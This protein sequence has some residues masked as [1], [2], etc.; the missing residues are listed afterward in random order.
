MEQKYINE[1]IQEALSQ[2]DGSEAQACQILMEWAIEDP[3]FLLS[4]TQPHLKSIVSYAIE[5]ALSKDK[6]VIEK[7]FVKPKEKPV[8]MDLPPESFGMDLLKALSGRDSVRFGLEG[9]NGR[10]LVTRRKQAS[11]QHIDI[12]KSLSS[13][14]PK[15]HKA[16]NHKDS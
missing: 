12:L 10:P 5:R 14:P 7:A 8:S 2:A 15:D 1:R 11:Q 16:G 13:Y 6:P 4:L 3:I 9:A